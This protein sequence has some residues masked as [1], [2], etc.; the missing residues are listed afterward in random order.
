MFTWIFPDQQDRARS[1]Q[2]L[3][4]VPLRYGMRY[5]R[6][7]RSHGGRAVAIWIPPGRSI[8]MGGLVRSG[9]LNVPLRVGPRAVGRFATAN[10]VMGKIHARHVPEPHWYLLI[11]A[12]DPDLQG[13]GI[14]SALVQDG[15][16]Q[17]DRSPRDQ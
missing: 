7:S 10:A 13:R 6:V 5:G 8:S 12:V 4:R 9:M 11:V 14:G 2:V 16:A 17:A 3:N 1:L 15:L